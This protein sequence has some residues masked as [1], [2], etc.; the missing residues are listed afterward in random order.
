MPPLL[1]VALGG[2]VGSAARFLVSQ[3]LA[4]ASLAF[5]V[6]TLV[7]NAVG[8]FVLGIVLAAIPG[9]P[10]SALRFAL[11][12]GFCGGFTTFSTFSAELV[13]LGEGGMPVRA[14]AYAG[15]SLTLGLVAMV[16][17][18]LVGRAVAAR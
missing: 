6:G 2:A 4:G 9:E 5:P 17:G 16:A 1:A 18:T 12:A 15:A 3:A 13:A 11:G 14:A 7:V 10:P 8:S